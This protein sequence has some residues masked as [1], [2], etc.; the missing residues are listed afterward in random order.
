[1][2]AEFGA[3]V[4][5]L[6]NGKMTETPVQTQYGFHIIKLIESRTPTPPALADVKTQVE[7]MVK[8]SRV[9]KYLGELRKTA[10]V[11]V[12]EVAVAAASSSSASSEAAAQ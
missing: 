6:E 10:K 9:E 2:V 3:A 1:M 5:Q 7:S 11:E 8:N 4:A 12:K